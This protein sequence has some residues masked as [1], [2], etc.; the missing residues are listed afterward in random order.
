MKCLQ[1]RLKA[2]AAAGLISREASMNKVPAGAYHITARGL[3]IIDV[4]LSLREIA[5]ETITYDCICPL[6]TRKE[7]QGPLTNI[8]FECPTRV[9]NCS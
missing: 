7:L 8:E 2:L 1:E 6:V 5:A 4:L 3:R 9:E